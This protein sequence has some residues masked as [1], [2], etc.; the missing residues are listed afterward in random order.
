MIA[1]RDLSKHYRVQK[2]SPGALAALR[3]ILRR[4]YETVRAVD[5]VSFEVASGERVGLLGSNG[6]GKT[7]TLKVLSGLLHP[8]A[9]VVRV[10]GV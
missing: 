4:E 5:G 6:A 2:R 10:A 9:G 7:T 1:V 8:T 3:S